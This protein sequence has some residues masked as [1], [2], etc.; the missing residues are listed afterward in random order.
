MRASARHR[1]ART[2]IAGVAALLALLAAGAERAPAAG[3]LT[4]SKPVRVNTALLPNTAL[5]GD[6]V[7]ARLSLVTEEDLVDMSSLKVYAS[8]GPFRAVSAPETDRRKVGSTEYIVWS[9]TLR[10]LEVSCVPPRKGKRYTF[11]PATVSFTGP[12][13]QGVVQSFNIAWPALLVYSR[14]D[15]IEVAARDPRDEPPWQADYRSLPAVAYRA[16]PGL[17]AAV[18][19]GGGG[20]LFVGAVALL[21][22]LVR[23]EEEEQ[24]V[25]APPPRVLTPPLEQALLMLESEPRT[26]ADIEPRRQALE[27]IAE[28][29]GNRDATDLERTARRLA[30]S[31]A[32]PAS[33]ETTTLVR[34]V[35]ALLERERREL[36]ARREA[37]L[38]HAE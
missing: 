7:T 6:T 11:T 20:L 16:A 35:R 15:Q 21:A 17:V 4:P 2:A 5:F 13:D 34:A 29:M 30:W 31:E 18:L 23:R 1:T 37:E 38:A 10:C 36:E 9:A 26:D 19:L 33:A 28:E 14:V 22:P 12:E 27:L 32:P 8:F 3:G 24:V 25:E